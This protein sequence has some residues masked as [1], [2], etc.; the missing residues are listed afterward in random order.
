M[1]RMAT[2]LTS[3]A[4]CF[5]WTWTARSARSERPDVKHVTVRHEPGPVLRLA[6]Q[7]RDLELGATRFWSNTTTASFRIG[8]LGRTTSNATSQSSLTSPGL[9]TVA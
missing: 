4:L 8:R 5:A 2:I 9:L 3:L 1:R 6:G 7:R